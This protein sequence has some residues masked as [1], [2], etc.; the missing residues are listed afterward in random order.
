MMFTDCNAYRQAYGLFQLKRSSMSCKNPANMA[1]DMSENDAQLQLIAQN[2]PFSDLT[3][4]GQYQ[5]D[6]MSV[7]REFAL[8]KGKIKRLIKIPGTVTKSIA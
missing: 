4:S 8:I 3:L 6:T 1:C 7:E 2:R 5:T